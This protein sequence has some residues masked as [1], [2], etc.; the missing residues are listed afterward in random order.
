MWTRDGPMGPVPEGPGP[1]LDV[2]ENFGRVGLAWHADDLDVRLLFLPAD[3][4]ADLVTLNQ[5]TSVWLKEP[6]EPP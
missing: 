1:A 2:G 3:P 4:D 6:R 5:E